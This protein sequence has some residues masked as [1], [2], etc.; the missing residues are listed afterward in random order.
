MDLIRLT[1][2][3]IRFKPNIPSHP[4]SAENQQLLMVIV[5]AENINEKEIEKYIRRI[6][7]A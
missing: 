1:F 7:T 6:I 3:Y 2:A 4:S 5:I